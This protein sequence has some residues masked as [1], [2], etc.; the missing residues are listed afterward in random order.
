MRVNNFRFLYSFLFL[1]FFCPLFSQNNNLAE[2]QAE[3]KSS[4]TDTGKI[5]ILL[6]IADITPE[7]DSAIIYL[8]KAVDISIKINSKS[9]LAV[10]YKKIG[11]RYLK[12]AEYTEAIEYFLKALKFYEEIGDKSGAGKCYYNIGL[13]Y[14]QQSNFT[15]EL[16]NRLKALKNFEEIGDKKLIGV[17]YSDIGII[18]Y[19]QINYPKALDYF[20][21]A[22]IICDTLKDDEGKAKNY[23]NIGLIYIDKKDYPKA[24]EYEVK[25]MHMYEKLNNSKD[26]SSCYI[27]I[28][29]IYSNSN[30]FSQAMQYY[31]NALKIKIELGDDALAAVCY[32]NIGSLNDNL[33]NYQDAID[34]SLKGI[35]ISKGINDLDNMRNGYKTLAN[36]YEELKDY[37]NAFKYE[38]KF[39]QLTDSIFNIENTKQMSDL[40][41]NFEVQKKEDELNSKSKAEKEKLAVIA[42]A[43]KKRQQTIIYFVIFILVIVCI[44]S[45]FL[46]NRY[47]VT[48]RQKNI[49]EK[50]K[51]VV[52]I[53]KQK[54][55]EKNKE[56][57]DSIQY[58]KRLQNAILPNPKLVKDFLVDSFIFFRPKDIVA[59]DF[60]WLY[61]IKNNREE[62]VILFAAADCTGH[63]VPGAMVSVVCANALN[64][65][66][67]EMA[68][69][70]PGKI[71][72]AVSKF[73]I[74]TFV[75]KTT[76]NSLTGSEVSDGMDISLGALN[77]T[78]R[79][80]QWSG[81]NN[82]LIIIKNNPSEILEIQPDKQPVGLYENPQPFTTHSLSLEKGEMIYLFSDGYADQ[83]GGE[84]GRKL[85]K[86]NFKKHLF[87]ISSLNI[88]KQLSAMENHFDTW[89]GDLQQID[90]ICVIGVRV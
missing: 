19:S 84:R 47:K 10:S 9:N 53:Q 74:E 79:Q 56:I 63:G 27:N 4:S 8:N 81:A 38:I 73:V 61:P 33:K 90:D 11:A 72:D 31:K 32:V 76:P 3:Y 46:W 22:L 55:E 44:A 17:S 49:I 29:I 45:V 71:L 54:V 69:T 59:G 62:T 86:A 78:T 75:Q 30:D 16:E 35:E 43:E 83:F 2:L 20:S 6:K 67:K 24:F 37:K 66:V 51:D 41:T 68:L 50:Q 39:K 34:Y 12:Q 65:A 40:K 23:N 14:H 64:R 26:L 42:E 52:Q 36:V 18:Y 15:K 13:V 87:E 25:A 82:S 80:F 70:E 58:A 88:D 7:N 89:K 5:S 85:M 21:K 1:F 57:L 77:L 28:A 48:E 60:Y